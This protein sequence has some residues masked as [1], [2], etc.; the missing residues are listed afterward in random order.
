MC[1]LGDLFFQAH[2]QIHM[3]SGQGSFGS[4]RFFHKSGGCHIVVAQELHDTLLQGFTG[5][6]LKLDAFAQSLP[7]SLAGAREKLQ[8]ILEQ[9]DQ[10][11]A[12]A[13]RTIW[14]LR[15]PAIEKHSD[16]SKVLLHACN[17]SLQG[18]NIRLKF[19]VD[20]TLRKLPPNVEDNL[21][22]VCE[23][24]VTN[25]VKHAHPKQT[26]V[27]LKFGSNEVQLLIQDDGC[28]FDPEGPEGSKSGH[29]GLVG[30]RERVKSLNGNLSLTSQNG[31]GTTI[32]VTI[33]L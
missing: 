5:I 4:S 26:Q 6:G 24:A 14:E 21:L 17:R 9:S 10:Y 15:S 23:E 7:D 2:I 20:G 27:C 19:S 28:G 33:N 30:I 32:L 31:K 13:R 29:F 25:V 1:S 8:H 22:R 11:L 12:E 18:T 3:E 16:F